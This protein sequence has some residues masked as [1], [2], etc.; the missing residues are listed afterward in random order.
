MSKATLQPVTTANALRAESHRLDHAVGKGVYRLS[1]LLRGK[2][3]NEDLA[4]QV[5][6]RKEFSIG[7]EG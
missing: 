6:N 5:S 1:G 2:I 3:E 7:R 4:L